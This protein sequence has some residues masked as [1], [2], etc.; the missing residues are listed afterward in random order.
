VYQWSMSV[1]DLISRAMKEKA[2][3]MISDSM[4]TRSPALTG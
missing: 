3:A 1:A 4:G 2:R